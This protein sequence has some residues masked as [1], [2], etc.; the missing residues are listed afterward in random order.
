M[1][2]FFSFIA[3]QGE[4]QGKFTKLLVNSSLVMPIPVSER[5]WEL[6]STVG[7]EGMYAIRT[8]NHNTTSPI[9][10]FEC[11]DGNIEVVRTLQD[12]LVGKRS[13]PEFLESIV[14]VGNQF[15]KEDIPMPEH[16]SSPV[17]RGQARGYL[18]E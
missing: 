4:W 11:L 16:Q 17:W 1:T 7:L 12:L 6:V 2:L 14:C 5:D 13:E 9:L 10:I 3:A 15:P 8:G 18:C